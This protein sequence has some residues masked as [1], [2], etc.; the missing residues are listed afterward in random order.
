[1]TSERQLRAKV[2]EFD[3]QLARLPVD[4]M[5]AEIR[6]RRANDREYYQLI[7]EAADRME[8]KA[9]QQLCD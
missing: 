3:P 9:C 1:M 8:R 6:R 4:W 2:A 7:N 5:I